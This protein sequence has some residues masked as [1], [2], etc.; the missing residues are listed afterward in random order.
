MNQG[1]TFSVA[2]EDGTPLGVDFDGLN[3]WVFGLDNNKIFKYSDSGVYTGFSFSVPP[4]VSRDLSSDGDFL[5]LCEF[6]AN[7]VRKFNKDGTNTGVTIP[8]ASQPFGCVVVVDK[9]CTDARCSVT[10][11]GSPTMILPRIA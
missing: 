8:V 11:A 10:D 7:D 1:F 5:W 4:Q 2:S 6:N 9:I 3:Y